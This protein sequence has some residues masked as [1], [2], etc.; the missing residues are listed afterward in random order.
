MSKP[1]RAQNRKKVVNKDAKLGAPVQVPTGKSFHLEFLNP[2]QKLAWSAFDKHDV[3]FLLGAPGTGKS[4]L[5]AAFAISE[6]LSKKRKKIVM[7]RPIVEAGEKL[8]YLPGTFEEKLNPYMLPLYDCVDRCLGGSVSQKELITK[9]T[10]V[11]PL[12]FMRGRALK[13][14]ENVITPDGLKPIGEIKIG[15]EII[16]SNGKSTKVIGVYPQGK[17]Q[18]FEIGFSDGTK[19]ICCENHLWNTMTLSEKRHNKG[20]TTKTTKQIMNN[21]INSHGQKIHKIPVLSNPVEFNYQEI[22]IDPYILGVL[23][24]DGHIGN[25]AVAVTTADQEIVDSCVNVLPKNHKLMKRNKYDYRFV[26]EDKNKCKNQ[27]KQQLKELGVY[28]KKSYEKFIPD[29]YKF[30]SVQCRLEMLR[31][32]LDTDGWIGTNR[33]SDR[34]QFYST[35]KKLAEDVMFLVRSLGGMAYHRIKKALPSDFHTYKNQIIRRM[36]DCYVVDIKIN[37]NPFKLTRKANKFNNNQPLNKFISYIEPKEQAE[38]TCI[39]VESDDSLYL[40]NDF[41]VTHNTFHD[42]VCILDEA[43]NC[44][45][46]Q[47]KL[48]LTR[49]GKNSKIIITGDPAQSDLAGPCAL[50]DVVKRL[51]NLPG[52]GI[53]T[54]DNSSIVRHPLI[55]EILD[56]LE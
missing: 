5:A 7:T 14:S 27:F 39:S 12:A 42:A 20:Y 21:L 41:I 53:I 22:T 48:F 19:S 16:G 8:G 10:E 47:L 23:L 38:C 44:S 35:S 6:I 26:V 28:D 37:L 51:E 31:G 43:Q 11:A 4:H 25:D 3:L 24:G 13:N 2:A 49:F 54:F 17:I 30:N 55:G 46:M 33:K 50:M 15:D 9:Y 1:K 36:H 45:K 56:R 18:T 32:L 29:N 34:I 40:T 52:V